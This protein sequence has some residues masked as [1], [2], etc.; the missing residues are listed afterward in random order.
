MRQMTKPLLIAAAA[1]AAIWAVP[2]AAFAHPGAA[3]VPYQALAEITMRQAQQQVRIERGVA[4]GQ[5]DRREARALTRDQRAIARAEAQAR[6]DGRIT[7]HEMA[8]LVAML[9]RADA[10]I[11]SLRHDVDVRRPHRD[12][13]H[14][15]G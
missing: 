10:R 7:R 12:G 4:R 9:D 6:A 8:T 1:A 13:A 3:A 15:P 2:G 11:R 5:I 14:W